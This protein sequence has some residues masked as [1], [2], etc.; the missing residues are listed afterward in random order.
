MCYH[1]GHGI[2]KNEKLAFEYY[3][4]VAN[5]DCAVGQSSLGYCYDIGLGIKNGCLLVRKSCK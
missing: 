2:A 4:K 5:K 3:E 1:Y